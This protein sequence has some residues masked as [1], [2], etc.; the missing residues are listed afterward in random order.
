MR[1]NC[2][3]FNL[4]KSDFFLMLSTVIGGQESGAGRRHWKTRRK[5]ENQRGKTTERNRIDVGET[6]RHETPP[7][8]NQQAIATLGTTR[9]TINRT[10]R[11]DIAALPFFCND[12]PIV[13]Q[14]TVESKIIMNSAVHCYSK[15]DIF[16]M[17]E[18]NAHFPRF[19]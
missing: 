8:W 14:S 10:R 19:F 9:S 6:L 11:S 12:K 4:I 17:L 13:I 5:W 16:N 3:W 15:S 18:K 2:Q 1:G 7:K